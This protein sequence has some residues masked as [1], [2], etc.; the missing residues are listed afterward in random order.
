MARI[1]TIKPEFCSSKDVGALSREARLFFLQLLTE[2]DDQGRMLWIP[3]RLCGVLYPFDT[4]IGQEQLELWA[5]ACQRREMVTLYQVDGVQYLQVTNW[6]KHQRINRPTASK[7]PA[8]LANQRVLALT[9]ESLRTH[10]ALSEASR[11]E[12]EQGRG[13]GNREGEQGTGIP[14]VAG[15]GSA[16]PTPPP[17]GDLSKR[18]QERL[19]QVTGDAVKAY[20]AL[21]GKP[22]GLLSAVHLVNDVREKQ[23]KRSLSVARAICDRQ[24]GS[25]TIT[26]VFWRDYFTV[27]AADDFHA[28][29][30]AGGK[31]HENWRPDFD[32]LTQ[33]DV[34]TR[35]FDRALSDDA[36]DGKGAG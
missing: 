14:A 9:D 5:L 3:R 34:M 6:D 32:Y 33:P 2:A 29:R 36:E 11:E 31:G 25:P 19:R 20:N 28:G 18:H 16:K 10:G 1:R 8:P 12:G 27:A 26:P 35:L 13:T 15:S 17:P 23:V 22:N 7:L 30:V 4:D 21:L 24:Y